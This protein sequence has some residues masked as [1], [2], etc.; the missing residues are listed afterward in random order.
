M[1]ENQGE[2]IQIIETDTQM[3][4]SGRTFKIAMIIIF[5]TINEKLENVT[6]NWNL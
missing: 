6:D 5:K 2:K 4:L 3:N 1:S